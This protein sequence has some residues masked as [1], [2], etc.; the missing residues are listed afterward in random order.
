[1]CRGVVYTVLSLPTTQLILDLRGA[2]CG[3]SCEIEPCVTIVL[4]MPSSSSSISSDSKLALT[5]KVSSL[6]SSSALTYAWTGV[7]V[8]TNSTTSTSTTTTTTTSAFA[9]TAPTSAMTSTAASGSGEGG[10]SGG[11]RLLLGRNGP[12]GRDILAQAKANG[13]LLTPLTR[14]YM[15][16]GSGALAVGGTYVFTVRVTDSYGSRSATVGG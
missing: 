15:A 16:L 9:T 4:S 7:N 8:S 5:A 10:P 1:M 14:S 12:G 13:L 11:G 2:I 6:N 3:R